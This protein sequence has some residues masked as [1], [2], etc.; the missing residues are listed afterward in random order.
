MPPT[1]PDLDGIDFRCRNGTGSGN[2]VRAATEYAR[3][4][5]KMFLRYASHEDSCDLCR[6]DDPTG[7]FMPRTKPPVC[8]CGLIQVRQ[9]IKGL[10]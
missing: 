6:L 8:D 4:L 3:H 9:L 10:V 1:R 7:L 2:D 5:E